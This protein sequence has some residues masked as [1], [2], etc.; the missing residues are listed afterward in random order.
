MAEAKKTDKETEQ[1]YTR[2]QLIKKADFVKY[3][4][5]LS[6]ALNEGTYTIEEAKKAID[7]FMERV[8]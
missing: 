4:D 6:V 3:K 2:G 8:V 5:V 7:D 1:K